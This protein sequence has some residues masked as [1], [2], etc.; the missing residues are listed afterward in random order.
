[1]TSSVLL[2]IEPVDPRI[3]MLEVVRPLKRD[4]AGEG[5]IAMIRLSLKSSGKTQRQGLLR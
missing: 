1:M 3:V 4:N 5:F 2:P